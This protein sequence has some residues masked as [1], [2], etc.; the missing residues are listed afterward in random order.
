MK[1]SKHIENVERKYSETNFPKDEK[2]FPD[3]ISGIN[4][5]YNKNQQK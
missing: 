1:N 4:Q 5:K 2:L 3:T